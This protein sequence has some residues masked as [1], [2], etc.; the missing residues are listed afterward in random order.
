MLR[1]AQDGRIEVATGGLNGRSP[2][3]CHTM[4]RLQIAHWGKIS[5]LDSGG[6]LTLAGLNR[7]DLGDRAP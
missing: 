4:G 6:D 2:M 5:A 1:V 3:F 7:D